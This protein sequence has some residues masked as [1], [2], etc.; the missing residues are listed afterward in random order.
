MANTQEQMDS[1]LP[2]VDDDTRSTEE[3][4]KDTKPMDISSVPAFQ[5]PLDASENDKPTGNIDETGAIEYRTALG[6]TYLVRRNPD[7][8]TTRTKI[9]EDVLPAVKEY[10]AD[11]TAPTA[12][13]AIA[14]AKA[15]AGDAWET[16]SIPGD[17]LSGEKGASDVTLGEVFELTGGTAAASTMFDVPGGRDTLRIF[18]GARAKYPPNMT[19]YG[20]IDTTFNAEAD[21]KTLENLSVDFEN[22]P[23]GSLVRVM[24]E[25]ERNPDKYPSTLKEIVAG[26]WFRGRDNMMRF[27]IDD[28]KSSIKNMDLI[29]DMDAYDMDAYIEGSD[30]KSSNVFPD[31]S[32]QGMPD[33]KAFTTLEDILEHD[34]LYNQYPE[35]KN[36]PVINDVE[37]FDKHPST[38][39]YFDP[40][41]GVIAINPKLV[42]SSEELKNTLIH[43]IQHLVQHLEG[44]ESGTSRYSG[45]VYQIKTA[46][47]KS[48]AAKK[49][50]EDYEKSVKVFDA[51]LPKVFEQVLDKNAEVARKVLDL[52]LDKVEKD[53]GVS[54]AEIFQ[55][56][57]ENKLLSEII[58][59][60]TGKNY[61]NFNVESLIRVANRDADTYGSAFV[62]TKLGNNFTKNSKYT[63]YLGYLPE[64]E[65]L[66]ALESI[67]RKSGFIIQ[68]ALKKFDTADG[69][70]AS[71]F[72]KTF[73]YPI[74]E[75]KRQNF[76]DR[77][78]SNVAIF[79]GLDVPERPIKPTKFGNHLVYTLK[80][81]EAEARLA[82]ARKDIPGSERSPEN[83]FDQEDVPPESQWGEPELKRA[84]KG[85][86]VI[87]GFKPKPSASESYR[88]NPD[89]KLQTEKAFEEVANTQRGNPELAMVEAQKIYGGGVMPNAL[90]HI[91][92]LTHRMAERG[93][94]FGSEYV[95]PK[96]TR[97]LDSL[98]SDYGFEKEMLENIQSNARFKYER[99]NPDIPFEQYK[100]EYED[101]IDKALK[102]YSEAHKKVPVY[103]QMQ[104]AGREAAIAIGEKRYTDAIEHLYTIDQAIKDGTYKQ[105][106]LEFDP[107]I[108]F[109][110]KNGLAKGGAVNNMSMKQQMSLFEYGGIADDGMTKDPVSGN[111][112]PPGSLAKEVRD[113]I[114]AMLS[115]G[116]YVVPADVLRYYGVNFFENLRG[117]AKQGLQNMEQN[118]RIGGTPMTQQD[119]ARNMQ[120]PVQA[121]Q[122]AMM[123][124]PMKIQQRPAP[125]A[126]GNSGM[127]M[128][129]YSGEDGSVVTGDPRANQYKSG[130]SPAR[131]RFNTPMFQGTSSQ[132]ANVAAAAEAAQTE[133]ITQFRTHYNQAGE[134]AQ[135]RYVGTTQE[136]MRIAEG[137]DDIISKY[138]LT[139]QE[140]NAYKAEM[141]KGSGG[142]D[143]GGDTDP[144]PT[145]SDT[146]W[147]DGI[148]W[149]DQ[150]SVK[151]WV[152][153]DNG[154]GMSSAARKIGGMGGI[155]GAVPQ[156][157]Q[158]QDIAKVRGV[159]DYYESIGDE[160]MVKYLDGE[161]KEAMKETGLLTSALDKL[162]LLTG[163]NYLN[164]M[165]NL[166][167][168]TQQNIELGGMSLEENQA[169]TAKAIQ[170][171]D[172]DQK[173]A[174]EILAEAQKSAESGS[175]ADIVEKSG[176]EGSPNREQTE[177]NLSD[178]LSGLETGAKTGTIQL[179]KGGL[180]AAPKP[181]KKTRKYNK[182]GLAGK[183]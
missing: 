98:L 102:K 11:P 124:S 29:T 32:I 84:K 2:A 119:V 134:T 92:D 63:D 176:E 39:G 12:D 175:T 68:D 89:I 173:T 34:E 141:S 82:A 20:S 183:K 172:D 78:P 169:M 65:K 101:K 142:G 55:G 79:Y 44:F 9:E 69:E 161:L 53:T 120:Q 165:K 147:M 138:P 108:D 154:L 123:Q 13:Q 158:A 127:P 166:D 93:G 104:L 115:E 1:M 48:A 96:V 143:G 26:N 174:A 16:I 60:K 61:L 42:T 100:K 59:E 117:Q 139:E 76:Y 95:A 164:Q 18:G 112:I 122:G 181:K 5:R 72:L 81:G 145:G 58:K 49:A 177:Q 152:E 128:Q 90:E 77:D 4:L 40:S 38:S 17:L 135:V 107:N 56:I 15:I 94:R 148:D 64:D 52:A 70:F 31:S 99:D 24:D 151:D 51:A 131:A 126:M 133:E 137:Q 57:S 111:N 91:G 37:Y 103:N 14:A 67:N 75:L 162:G 23:T 36:A 45:E 8:R 73:G 167:L 153:S 35:L 27:E 129:G 106:A 62:G 179:N 182:G 46:L 155:L 144:T 125:Q 159:R 116:E 178:V 88:Q 22:D 114:P 140:Y 85:E 74:G 71:E 136:N 163:K 87:T 86:D 150:Q 168:T 21:F 7:Q 47:D 171:K 110:K 97:M 121:A 19:G 160:E 50:L 10:L 41:S 25:V 113:D 146:S 105:A 157:V 83:V 130:W 149:S 80:R 132:A 180:M 118:G 66:E 54:A 170:Q 30:F 33:E 43:E 6:N 28:S 109:R 156:V 3:Y